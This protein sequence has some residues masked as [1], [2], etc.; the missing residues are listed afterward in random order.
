MESQSG[1]TSLAPRLSGGP[2]RTTLFYLELLAVVVLAVAAHAPVAAVSDPASFEARGMSANPAAEQRALEAYGKLP[3]AFVPNHG[4]TDKRIRFSAEA[5]GASFWFT[6]REAVFAFAG[7][8][9]AHVLRLGFVGAS[10]GVEIVGRS[11]GPGRV[12]YLAGSDHTK[13]RTG[14][15]T[16]AEVIYRDLW[17]GIDLAFRGGSGRLKYEFR[18]A[19]GADPA[20]VRLAY[21][22]ADRLAVG[23]AG[24]L[25]IHTAGR[26]LRDSPPVTYQPVGANRVPVAS[27]YALEGNGYGFALGAYD[28]K[29][30][31]VIDPTLV[32]STYLGGSGGENGFAIAV[33]DAGEAFVTGVTTSSP[34]FTAGCTAPCTVLDASLG[35]FDDAF[36]TKLNA[37]GTALVYST[38]LGGS[39][40]DEGFAIA[41]DDAGEAFVTGRTYSSDFT[42]GCT[43]PC[44]L[45]DAS[46]SGPNDAFVT[47]LNAAGTALVYA[48]YLGGLSDDFGDGIAV[49]GG[50]AAYVMGTTYSPDFTAGCTAP[51]TVLDASWGGPDAFVTKLDAAGTALV[52]STFVGGTGFDDSVGEIALDGT[53]GASV[54]GHTSSADFTAGCIAPC[55]VLDASLGGSEDVFVTKLN[56]AG[57]GL[58]FST[59]LGGSGREDGF[60]IAVDDAGAAFVTGS[61]SSSDFT[62]GCTAPCTVLDASLGGSGDAFVTKLVEPP[63]GPPAALALAPLTATNRVETSHTVT[64]TVEDAA[65]NLVPNVRVQFSVTG[66]VNSSGACTTETTGQCDFTYEGPTFPGADAISAFADTDNDGAHDP[67]EPSRAATKAWALPASTPGCKIK[68]A[69]NGKIT[70]LN[71][72]SATFHGHAKLTA[73][74]VRGRQRYRDH[75]PAQPLRMESINLLAVICNADRTKATL[76]GDATIDGS[77]VFKYRI[78]VKDMGEPGRGQ[79][80][81]GI[82]L[83]NGYFSGHRT[84]QKGNVQIKAHA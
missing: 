4:Q 6:E 12:N 62:A 44:T 42:A 56:A 80:Q 26:V 59:F 20:R 64:A 46:L 61:T 83:S 7:R 17:P 13:W 73:S 77:G 81:Y 10:T 54:S 52:Y 2:F 75:G 78:R 72:D 16:Y 1:S 27:R 24:E 47:K 66:S 33:D 32:Y 9:K 18:L 35:G 53:G 39:G 37:A 14:L 38:Y 23:R 45:L 69:D 30:P 8:P 36:V 67:S 57:T 43:T 58:V 60:G 49:D 48:T 3:L 41:V 31:L 65:G 55:V 63:V 21:D 74:N 5:G 79:D 71:G 68:I 34:D 50:G 84:L 15:P 40:Q 25:R 76:F 11:P 70:A 28:P 19:P 29:R 51:C 82:L 22:G